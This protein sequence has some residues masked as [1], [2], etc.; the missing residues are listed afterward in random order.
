MRWIVLSLL[1]SVGAP[2]ATQTPA[3]SSAAALHEVVYVRSRD[4]IRVGGH[5]VRLNMLGATLIALHDGNRAARILVQG[6]RAAGY[7]DVMAVLKAI[8]AAGFVDIAL[9]ADGVIVE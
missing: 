4:D 7:G 5:S 6:D 9:A 2:V 3:A 1:L 8:E